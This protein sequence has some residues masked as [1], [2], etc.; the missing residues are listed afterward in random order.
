MG[1]QTILIFT[2]LLLGYWLIA[3]LSLFKDSDVP[4]KYWRSLFLL[5]VLVGVVYSQYHLRYYGGG[6]TW[7]FF[8][9]SGIYFE[10]I[11]TSFWTYLQLVFGPNGYK[12]VPEEFLVYTD[13]SRYWWDSS[14]YLLIRINTFLR[15]LS[16]GEYYVHLVFWNFLSILGIGYIYRF[17]AEQLTSGRRVLFALLALTP[18][19]LFWASGL[20]KEALSFFFIGGVIWNLHQIKA[21]VGSK[22]LRIV[23][24]VSAMYLLVV[25]R[26]YIAVLL[27]PALIAFLW[28]ESGDTKSA[29]LKY[30]L[31]YF[32]CFV[33]SLLGPFISEKLDFYGR[34]AEMLAITKKYFPGYATLDAPNIKAD[35]WW[36][37]YTNIP[38]ALYN[39]FLKPN[40]YDGVA[41]YR[42]FAFVETYL[43]AAAILFGVIKIKW[44]SFL[45]N[46]R[47]LFALFF[48]LSLI[49]IIGLV[50]VNMGA[51]VRYRTV[52]LAFIICSI[53]L[54]TRKADSVNRG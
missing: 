43:I 44:A 35:E 48:G 42:I 28:V 53:Y 9:E 26:I 49:T 45:E 19:I 6:D 16:F 46:N 18:S 13:P 21:G 14:E 25:M 8:R 12:P 23:F 20:H 3:R 33:F 39:V 38:K 50:S 37:F 17:F 30:G 41:W 40:F 22:V 24:V 32:A 15:L 29:L 11:R 2:Y 54:G 31:V 4:T 36:T 10:S 47:A 1:W 52:A 5:K 7:T 51:I 27:V 34:I